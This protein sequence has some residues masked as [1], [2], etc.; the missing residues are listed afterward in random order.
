MAP[1]IKELRTLV[2]GTLVGALWFGLWFGKGSGELTASEWPQWRGPTG[3]GLSEERDLPTTWGGAENIAVRWKSPLP[4]ADA[5]QSSPIVW[6]DRVFVTTALNRPVEHHV[7]CY[8]VSDGERL[9]DTLVPPGPWLLSDLRGGYACA[10]PATDG[11]RVYVQFGSAVLVALDFA[12]NIQ[13]RREIEPHAFDVAIASSPLVHQGK[14]ILLCDQ[15]DKKS[16]IAAFDAKT[17]VT[18]WQ[19][20]RPDAGFNHSTP[21]LTTID[22]KPGSKPLLLVSASHA[23]Q[24][25]D[26]ADGSVLWWCRS[27]GD[28]STPVRAGN[29]VYTDEGRGGPGICVDLTGMGDVSATHRKWTIANGTNGMDSPIIVGDFLYRTSVALRCYRLATGE[30][31]WSQRLGGDFPAS[32]IATADGLIYYAS[33]GKSWVIRA[34]PTFELVGSSDLGDASSCSPAVAHGCIF[35][36]GATTLFCI[37]KK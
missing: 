12:G 31:V 35:L 4:H 26:P 1:Y 17:G 33:A 21:L 34:G 5:S 30:E 14:V 9:W 8:R 27:K 24:G 22:G 29:L 11:E 6:G 25:L 13:W 36:K 19:Q 18:A 7:T 15:T 20:P 28:V 10:T 23:L 2:M 3:M 32:P 37:G 16:F